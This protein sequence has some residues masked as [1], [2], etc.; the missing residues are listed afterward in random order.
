MNIDNMVGRD[1]EIGLANL[2]KL[3][4]N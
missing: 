3:T 2:K 1:F 4:E